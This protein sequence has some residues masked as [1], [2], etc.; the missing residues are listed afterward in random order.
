MG[1]NVIISDGMGGG[2]FDIFNEKGIE[3]NLFLNIKMIIIINS[4]SYFLKKC[5]LL[6]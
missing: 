6:L 2:P 5:R 1:V 3:V 4:F